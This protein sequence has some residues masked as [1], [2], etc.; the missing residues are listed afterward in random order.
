MNDDSTRPSAHALTTSTAAVAV[1]VDEVAEC[2][3][4][5]T[6]ELPEADL[7]LLDAINHELAL[8]ASNDPRPS[9]PEE[10]E[11]VAELL[12]SARRM[13]SMTREQVLQERLARERA[14]R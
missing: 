7:R 12:A 8:D 14:R 3:I 9:T 5:M 1:P 6:C 13:K 2:R 11:A 4:D 10:D